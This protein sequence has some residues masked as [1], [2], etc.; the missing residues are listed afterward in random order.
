[1][2]PSVTFRVRRLKEGYRSIAFPP[3]LNQRVSAFV[4]EMA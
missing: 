2:L 4:S 1:M 3:V